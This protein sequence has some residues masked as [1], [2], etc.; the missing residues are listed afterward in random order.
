M[1]CTHLAF[2]ESESGP[3]KTDQKEFCKKSQEQRRHI[4][5]APAILFQVQTRPVA[6]VTGRPAVP[7]R[8]EVAMGVSLNPV[9][10]T[11]AFNNLKGPTGAGSMESLDSTKSSTLS[12]GSTGSAGRGVGGGEGSTV[13]ILHHVYTRVLL[14]VPHV[15]RPYVL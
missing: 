1:G 8:E 5:L 3:L 15:F 2:K 7:H 9:G 12:F 6:Q 11:A 4:I 10:R 13:A 14:L